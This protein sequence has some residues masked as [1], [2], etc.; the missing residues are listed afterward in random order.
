MA[1]SISPSPWL[2]FFDG[3]VSAAGYLLFT[4]EAG[5]TTKL[6]TYSDV[7]LTTPNTNPIVLD[8]DGAPHPGCSSAW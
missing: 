1:G 3:G 4:Y 2:Y 8:A 6:A 5:T 7:N